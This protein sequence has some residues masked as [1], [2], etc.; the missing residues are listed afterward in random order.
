MQSTAGP[1]GDLLQ[2]L[3]ASPGHPAPWLVVVARAALGIGA[4]VTSRPS[5]QL[6]FCTEGGWRLYSVLRGH[7]G[8]CQPKIEPKTGK[9]ESEA[10]AEPWTSARHDSAGASLSGFVSTL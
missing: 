8:E 4:E 3:A 5:K 9:C 10:P 1:K 7:H 6:F 2:V